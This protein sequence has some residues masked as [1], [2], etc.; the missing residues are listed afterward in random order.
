MKIS[1]YVALLFLGTSAASADSF[2]PAASPVGTY[3]SRRIGSIIQIGAGEEIVGY[4]KGL[5]VGGAIADGDLPFT[6]GKQQYVIKSGTPMTRVAT[7]AALKVCVSP[8][9]ADRGCA[10]D[11]D[12]DGMFDRVAANDLV[13]ATPLTTKVAYQRIDDLRVPLIDKSIYSDPKNYR[14]SLL[15]QGSDGKTIK[16][17]YREFVNDLARDPFSEELTIPL[18]ASLPSQIAAKGFVFTIR[19]ISGLGLTFTI[20]KIP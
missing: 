7:K 9:E 10:L 1:A 12:G 17:S 8:E 14:Y 4:A 13:K 6:F 5:I 15:Y 20:D 18:G 19:E 2:N 16:I 11:D 3:T